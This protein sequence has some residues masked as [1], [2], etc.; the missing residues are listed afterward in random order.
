METR[1]RDKRKILLVL[2]LLVMPFLALAFYAGGGGRDASDD[3]IARGGISTAL[4]DANFKAQEPVDKMG[5]YAKGEKDTAGISAMAR[6]MGF[7]SGAADDRTGE[8]SAKLEAL[9]REISLPPAEAGGGKNTASKNTDNGMSADVDRLEML[10][11]AMKSDKGLDPEMEQMN[12]ML[13][14]ILDIQDPD[15]TQR[16]VDAKIH[17]EPADREFM[18]VPAEIATG[19]K[20]VQGATISLRLL[21]SVVLKN[22]TIPKGHEVFG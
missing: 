19:G 18:A 20:V 13:E 9:Q 4:P 11:K 14:K 5:F 1:T 3:V 7:G 22:V 8:I 15:R 21:D 12:A 2:P 17:G 10:M 16:K 6:K